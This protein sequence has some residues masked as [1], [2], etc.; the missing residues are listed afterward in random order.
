MPPRLLG[1]FGLTQYHFVDTLDRYPTFWSFD[2][3]AVSKISNQFAAMPS[4]HCC[5]ALWC[6]CV[7]VSHVKHVWAKVLAVIYPITTVTVIVVTAN[8][9]Y[10]DALGGF[11]VFGVGY[12]AARIFTRAGRGPAVAVAPPP[13]PPSEPPSEPSVSR[14]SGSP[15]GP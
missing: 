13:E 8:H 5:W 3:G 10:L 15:G 6:A 12:V 4:V 1:Q 11:F 14:P 2:S 7:I 9:Y